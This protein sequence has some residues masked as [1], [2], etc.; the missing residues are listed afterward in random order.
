[1]KKLGVELT[2][3]L[4]SSAMSP[5]TRCTHSWLSMS[6]LNFATSSFRSFAIDRML[7]S[8]SFDGSCA[9]AYGAYALSHQSCLNSRNL[10][11]LDA[12][13]PAWCALVTTC[14][15]TTM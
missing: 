15:C 7:S 13:H 10:P 6:A 12:A 8:P 5:C 11:C 14:G 4:A 9:A 1:M 2:C 3:H